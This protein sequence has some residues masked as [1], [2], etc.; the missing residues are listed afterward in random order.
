[1]T[2]AVMIAGTHSGVSKTTIA[3]G[4]MALFTRRGKCIFDGH[5]GLMAYNTLAS[6]MHTHPAAVSM[7]RFVNSCREYSR[8]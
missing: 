5:D 4:L 2:K 3:L 6:Y 7:E 1:M 8:R